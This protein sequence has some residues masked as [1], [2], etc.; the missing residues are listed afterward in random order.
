MNSLQFKKLLNVIETQAPE[1]FN[2]FI[3]Y[4]ILTSSVGIIICLLCIVLINIC[5]YKFYKKDYVIRDS[6]DFVMCLLVY[7]VCNVFPIT[8]TILNII[9]LVKCFIAPKVFFIQSLF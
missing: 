6:E 7:A 9:T 5:I 3:N 4:K 8:F 1:L 2:N